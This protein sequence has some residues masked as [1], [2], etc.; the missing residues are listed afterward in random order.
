MFT[1][2]LIMPDN[3]RSVA[4]R[5]LLNA[6]VPPQSA[7]LQV[8]LLLEAELAGR[9]SH[10]LLRLPRLVE[11]IRN[12]VA[13]ATARGVHSW[14]GALLEVDGENGL[15][16]VVAMAAL[17]AAAE[18]LA[19]NGVTAIAIRNNNHLGMLAWYA[20]RMTA[21]GMVLLAFSTS[22]AL[23][24]AWGGRTAMLGTNP[25][26]IGV[27]T[28]G[29]PFVLDMATSLVSMGQIHDHAQRGQPL[30]EGWALDAQGNPTTDAEAAKSGSIAPFGDAKGYALGL[31][32]EML[33]TSLAGAAI[34]RDVVGTLD[35]TQVCNKGDLFVLV[36]PGRQPGVAERISAY[37]DLVRASG[38]ATRVAVP[39]DRARAAR[40]RSRAEGVRLPAPLWQR[41]QSLADST[42]TLA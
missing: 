31:A 35:S 33:V 10:G 32:I 41:L 38:G 2:E 37:L 25:V 26:A 6:A 8:D 4:E 40:A 18:K 19:Q 24:H 27:P 15:G 23:V 28:A 36:D 21:R 16:P 17:D 3:V 42:S 30:A 39:G 20:N 34:G 12:G 5:A 9:A 14:R 1:T 13:S 11:R 7:Q 29:E 22:E